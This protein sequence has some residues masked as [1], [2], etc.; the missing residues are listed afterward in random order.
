MCTTIQN[1]QLIT[2][3]H[4][5][6]YYASHFRLLSE[7]IPTLGGDIEVLVLFLKFVT[8]NMT[9]PP[10]GLAE[11]KKIKVEYLPESAVLP[12]ADACF[13]YLKLPIRHNDMQV[14]RLCQMHVDIVKTCVQLIWRTINGI[15]IERH[16]AP[17]Q[18]ING[19]FSSAVAFTYM[20]IFN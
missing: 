7:N 17:M 20:L 10:L 16:T 12:D 18:C 5:R 13:S 2:D 3:Y 19:M 1:F 8:A 4:A 6:S 14:L 15:F 9:I 11:N